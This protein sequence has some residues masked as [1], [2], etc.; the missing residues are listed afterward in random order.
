MV[1]LCH[2]SMCA[3]SVEQGK[4]VVNLVNCFEHGDGFAHFVDFMRFLALYASVLLFLAGW[5]VSC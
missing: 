1:S 2:N 3:I 5:L 4:Q